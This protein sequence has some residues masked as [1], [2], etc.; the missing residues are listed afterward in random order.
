[1]KPRKRE[2]RRAG[3]LGMGGVAFLVHLAFVVL[4][5]LV[6]W[7]TILQAEPTVYSVTLASVP[8]SAPRP[9]RLNPPI[10]LSSAEK[11]AEKTKKDDIVLKAKKPVEEK[12]PAKSLREALEEVRKKRSLG[13]ENRK[14]AT[15]R[16]PEPPPA[17]TKVASVTPPPPVPPVTP[18]TPGTEGPIPSRPTLSPSQ[19]ESRLREYSGLVW[20]KIKEEWKIPESLFKEMV[21]LEAVIV[22]KIGKD[23]RIRGYSYDSTSGN[24]SYDEMAMRAIKRAEPLPEIPDEL[25]EETIEI[26]IRFTAENYRKAY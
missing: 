15:P 17:Q 5:S 7:H 10:D 13:E 12:A 21:D 23:G 6:S 9:E 18:A 2:R 11:K 19:M 1:M 14:T 20:A 22:V 25:N 4:C 8:S 26:G 3:L 24:P 16:E